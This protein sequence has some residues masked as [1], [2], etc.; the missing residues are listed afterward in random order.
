MQL[1][2]NAMVEKKM[3][4]FLIFRVNFLTEVDGKINH[5]N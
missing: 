5:A 4:P 1:H 2:K 3:K